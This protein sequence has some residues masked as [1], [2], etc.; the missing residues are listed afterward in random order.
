MFQLGGKR[1]CFGIVDQGLP[2]VDA[3]GQQL[4]VQVFVHVLQLFVFL[5][6]NKSNNVKKIYKLFFYLSEDSVNVWK[7]SKSKDRITVECLGQCD[8]FMKRLKY[9]FVLSCY[10]I[11]KKFSTCWRWKSCIAGAVLNYQSK[12]INCS[13]MMS[14]C[15]LSSGKSDSPSTGQYLCLDHSKLF[16]ANYHLLYLWG[17][18]VL[19]RIFLVIFFQLE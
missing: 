13:T 8:N 11:V 9:Y 15:I 10:R 18:C 4:S 2:L 6:S 12:K 17:K 7:E 5:E 1:L 14:T 3:P 16:G 19:P